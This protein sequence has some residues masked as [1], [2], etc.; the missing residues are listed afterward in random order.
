MRK[1]RRGKKDSS[2]A[3]A[4]YG[5]LTLIAFVSAEVPFRSE[6]MSD[7]MRIFSGMAGLQGLGLPANWSSSLSLT[8]NALMLPLIVL[9]L[10][11][12]YLCP[13]TAEIM[14]RVN[15]ALEWDKW[16]QV[17]APLI[18]LRFQ[19]TTAWVLAISV[20]LFLGF[21]FISRANTSFIYFQ[22]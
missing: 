12:I 1:R 6:N 22:F 13:D 4:M 18:N 10:V 11:I 2:L 3:T 17:S 20:A 16:R 14:D 19:F 15:P 7:A 8:G 21:T 5:A 9:G